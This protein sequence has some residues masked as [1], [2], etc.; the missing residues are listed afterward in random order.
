MP[1]AIDSTAH[2]RWPDATNRPLVVGIA[3][4][5]ASGKTSVALALAQDLGPAQASLLQHD[6]YYRDLT[7]LSLEAREVHNYDHPSALE[8]DLLVAHVDRLRAGE[9]IWR[10]EYSFSSQTR[11]PDAARIDPRPIPLIEGIMV[12]Q[13]PDLRARMDLRV[14]VDAPE[15]I[16]LS[17]RVVRDQQERGYSEL[18]IRRQF[19]A[20]VKPMHDSFVEPSRAFADIIIPNGYNAAAVGLIL[21]ALR[22]LIAP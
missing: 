1:S 11:I 4:G 22:A 19:A 3:G 13:D 6:N 2:R 8:T 9:S 16:R 18:Q 10:P 20:T 17:R 5:S 21:H 15:D 14:F 12:L 7:H